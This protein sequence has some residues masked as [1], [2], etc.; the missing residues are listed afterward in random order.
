MANDEI[1]W[2]NYTSLSDSATVTATSNWHFVSPGGKWSA[3][4]DLEKEKN[5]R[6]LYRITVVNP[7]TEEIVGPVLV[8]AKDEKGA[9]LK[10]N[11]PQEIC[12]DSDKYDFCIEIVGHVRSKK[13]TQKVKVVE[14][15]EE[16]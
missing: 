5:M 8:V 2:G 14:K 3:L 12:A 7:R 13:E 1:D 10:A 11:L 6:R 4:G 9:L 15:G 16:G